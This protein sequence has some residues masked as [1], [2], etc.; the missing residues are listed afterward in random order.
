[1]S[2]KSQ[3]IDK[4]SSSLK[5]RENYV[6]SKVSTNVASQLR[7]IRRR[8]ELTQGDL[9][10]ISDMKQSRISALERPGTRWNVE[11]LVRLVA[12]LR[13]G[14]VVKV[15]PFSEMLRWENEF[16]QDVFDVVA[17]ENDVE[18]RAEEARAEVASTDPVGGGLSSSQAAWVFSYGGR[19]SGFNS[20]GD[21][22]SENSSYAPPSASVSLAMAVALSQMRRNL[23]SSVDESVYKVSQDQG[24]AGVLVVGESDSPQYATT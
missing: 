2:E 23:S 24:S 11:T 6:R 17:I 18:F 14:L 9:A 7:A 10:E 13:V 3:L 20:A 8:Q 4:L 1:M 5:T 22:E 15:V 19:D 16:S 21:P 12:A